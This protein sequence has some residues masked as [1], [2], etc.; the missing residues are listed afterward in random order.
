M[1]KKITAQQRQRWVVPSLLILSSVM[2][3]LAWLGHLRFHE[4]WSFTTALLASWALVLPEY[5]MNTAATRWGY[6]LYSGA[7]MAAMH[8]ASGVVCVALV[9]GFVLGESVSL[10]QVAGYAV[11]LGSIFLI[12]SEDT[13]PGG[14][15]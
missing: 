13:P 15:P 1:E 11:L 10:R 7:Q 8:L 6:G 9:S 2:M 4:T 14:I 12:F 5:A 3:S